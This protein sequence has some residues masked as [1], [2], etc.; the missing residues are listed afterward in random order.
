M[1]FQFNP[2]LTAFVLLLPTFV[3]KKLHFLLLTKH[4]YYFSVYISPT[5]PF[6]HCCCVW[7][8]ILEYLGQWVTVYYILSMEKNKHIQHNYKNNSFQS[9]HL[10]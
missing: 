10:H 9:L 3:H 2:L 7:E 1:Y 6:E 5:N 8:I 4:L